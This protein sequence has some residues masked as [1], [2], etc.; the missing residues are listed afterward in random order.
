VDLYWKHEGDEPCHRE[1]DL[2]PERGTTRGHRWRAGRGRGWCTKS[3]SGTYVRDVLARRTA[4]RDA[5]VLAQT[6]RPSLPVCR[7][8]VAGV[9]PADDAAWQPRKAV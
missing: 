5:A 1:L 8:V 6:S 9:A 4:R 2:D 7:R 3:L